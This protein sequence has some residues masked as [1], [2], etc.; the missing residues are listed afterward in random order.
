MLQKKTQIQSVS[1]QL[2]N[3]LAIWG[4]VTQAHTT[5]GG[6]QE[7]HQHCNIATIIN[8]RPLKSTTSIKILPRIQTYL[9][10]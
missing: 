8:K 9:N 3:N 1:T 6:G 2:R 4:Y 5:I 10:N 7:Y